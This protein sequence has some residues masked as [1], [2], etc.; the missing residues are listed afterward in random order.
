VS[1]DLTIA[2][3]TY[4]FPT[5]GENN[6]GQ[7]VT[8]WATAVSTFLLQRTGGAFSLT[9]DV[10]F[11][12]NFAT[13]QIYLKSRTSNI[14]TVGFVR[15]ANADAIA[16]RNAT[17]DAN[18]L[19][20]VDSSN[21]LTFDGTVIL[22]S[23]GA[24]AA[25]RALI[26]DGSGDITV[27]TVTATELGY[28][29]GVTSAIQ[30]QLNAKQATGNYIT[31]LT[32]EVTASGPGSVAATVTN[33][34]VIAKVL[35]GYASAPGT[36]SASDSILSAIQKL[37]GNLYQ[38][39]VATKTTTF[40]F[41][42]TDYFV[43]CDTSGGAYT[44]TLP[45]VTGNS[46]LTYRVKKTTADFS[47]LTISGTGLSTTLN[48]LGEEVELYCDG[49]NWN[50]LSRVNNTNWTSF[51]AS[52]TAVSVNPAIGNGTLTANYRRRGDTA[53]IEY[54]ITAGSTT[55]FGTGDWIFGVPSG[56]TINT[57]KLQQS[58]STNTIIGFGGTV[59]GAY[60]STVAIYDTTTQFRAAADN[61]AG[62]V[63]ASSP[64]AWANG[65]TL[66]VTAI[67]PITGWN[68]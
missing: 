40:T 24:L 55:T 41:A 2:G 10:N 28:V 67:V 47:A 35:T 30:T 14:A 12:A 63:T 64:E 58:S 22:T 45:T 37:N 16:W 54:Q 43:L 56:L 11:G 34:A 48:T 61:Q 66:M 32:G 51:T 9:N 52:W 46:G 38:R 59:Q 17:N 60:H 36:I 65:Q 7:N 6:W 3:T 62:R 44:G 26:S 23:A 5:V 29:S 8:N 31:D 4:P 1:V 20:G 53:E 49:T 42:A 68:A 39:S 21:K 33:S 19:L 57:T 50:V 15:L 13:V 27:S 18:L 25:N